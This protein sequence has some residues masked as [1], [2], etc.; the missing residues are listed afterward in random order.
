MTIAGN[1]PCG[2]VPPYLFQDGSAPALDIA[3]N[4]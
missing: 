2:V 3:S 4:N 1:S